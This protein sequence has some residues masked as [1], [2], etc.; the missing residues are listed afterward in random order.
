MKNNIIA[1]FFV[2]AVSVSAQVERVGDYAAAKLPTLSGVNSFTNATDSTGVGSGSMILSGGLSVAKTI[3]SGQSIASIRGTASAG[4]SVLQTGDAF[5]RGVWKTDGI[6]YF[7]TGAA[8]QDASFGRLGVNQVGTS[9]YFFVT[10]T[11]QATSLSN[12]AVRLS[13]GVSV[14]KNLLAGG[15][16]TRI[17]AGGT[18]VGI[19]NTVT[20][21]IADNWAVLGNGTMEWGTGLASRDTNLYRSAANVLKTDDAFVAFCY[22]GNTITTGTGTLTLGSSSLTNTGTSA[23]TSFTGSGTSIGTNT[24]DQTTITGNAGTAT[25]LATARTISI[26]GDLAY[27]SPSFDGSGNVTA[28]GT[29]ATVSSAGT[30]GSSTAIPVIT[31]NAKG[32]TTGITTAAVVAPADTLTGTTLAANVVSSSLTSA[33]GGSFG[34][35]AYTAA[36]AYATS[37]QGTKADNAGAVTGLIKSDGAAAFSAASA[38]TDYLAPAGSGASLTGITGGQVAN[39]PA[40]SIAATDVQAALNELDTEKLTSATV[41][42]AT[43]PLATYAAGTAYSLTASDAAVDFGTTDPTIEFVTAGTYLVHGRALLKYNGATYAGNETATLHLQRT[44]NTP[45]AITNATTTAALRIITTITDTVGV[46][47]MPPVIYTA[48]A[49]DIITI[50]G[51]VSATPAAGSVDCTEASVVAIRLY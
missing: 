17:G 31:I 4:F 11:E 30:T 23:L 9:G 47:P 25:A 7:G 19:S 2:L 14:A 6:L 43:T 45:A 5:D 41:A 46:M 32:L 8:T 21:D 35:A 15:Q 48:G 37:A 51:A 20:G 50:Y 10:Q 28:A 42:T 44:N 24:G 38:G 16:M 26:T 34:T 1:W 49:G 18:A 13:G 27:T 22:N 3:V 36:T 29:L 39:T 12:G 40:G 33:A